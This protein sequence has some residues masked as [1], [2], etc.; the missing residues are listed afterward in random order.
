MVVEYLDLKHSFLGYVIIIELQAP[1]C[2]YGFKKLFLL[3]L[4]TGFLWLAEHQVIKH[5]TSWFISRKL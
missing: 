2:S 1:G 5:E 3:I 4:K